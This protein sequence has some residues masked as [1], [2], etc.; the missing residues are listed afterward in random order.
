M[1]LILPIIF[2]ITAIDGL[3]Y[4]VTNWSILQEDFSYVSK[5]LLYNEEKR[6]QLR[7]DKQKNEYK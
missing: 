6:L 7:K 2:A 4:R 1:D 3:C 5:F